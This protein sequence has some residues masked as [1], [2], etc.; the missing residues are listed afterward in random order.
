MS[1]TPRPR[2]TET[3]AA[4]YGAGEDPKAAEKLAALVASFRTSDR[5]ERLIALRSSDPPLFAS[6]VTPTLR[7]ELGLYEAAKAAYEQ[8]QEA[9]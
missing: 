9:Q 4:G 2:P 8:E 3:L 1:A 7:M 6:V 5:M